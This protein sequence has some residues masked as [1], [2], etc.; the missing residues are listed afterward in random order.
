MASFDFITNSVGSWTVVTSITYGAI[1]IFF[2][3]F[4]KDRKNTRIK[5]YLGC[6]ILGVLVFDF[7]TG[8]LASPFLFGITFEAAFIGQIPF[9]IIHLITTS[10][11]I[12]V[13]TPLLDKQVLL[14]VKFDDSKVLAYLSR[15]NIIW[16]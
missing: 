14:N 9:T 10:A 1:G 8:V 2:Y 13:I 16:G 3:Y 7:I 6:G 5:T 12:I 4:L 11:F 15:L